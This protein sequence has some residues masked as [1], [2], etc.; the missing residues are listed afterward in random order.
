M[1]N[2]A[3]IS[4]KI[5]SEFENPNVA[6]DMTCGNG[7]DTLYLSK[8]AKNVFSFDV[9]DEAIINTIKLLQ[10]NNVNNVRVIKESHDLYDIYVS[11]EVDLVIYNLGYLPNS[12]KSI[13]TDP[14]IV[15][16]SLEK[17]LPQLSNSGIVVIVIYSHNL[18][19][20]T[21]VLEFAKNIGNN[22]DVSRFD[23]LN[24]VNS[25]YIIKIQKV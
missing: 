1:I 21:R 24:K 2:I 25:P 16:N 13:K 22:Y 8:I 19:E 3:K 18:L 4:H 12:D 9:Q 20:S 5:L 23:I 10:E 11:D 15:L 14:R 6:I 17:I 7:H